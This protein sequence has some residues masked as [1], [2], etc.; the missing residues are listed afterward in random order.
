MWNNITLVEKKENNSA[1][2]ERVLSSSS[3]SLL[4]GNKENGNIKNRIL[5]GCAPFSM[6][7]VYTLPAAGKDCSRRG[8]MLKHCVRD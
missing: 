7:L 2:R 4:P 3:P 5:I 6:I 8:H 1:E